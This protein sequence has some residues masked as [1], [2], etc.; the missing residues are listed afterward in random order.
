M[1]AKNKEKKLEYFFESNWFVPVY[2]V[3]LVFIAV[4]FAIPIITKFYALF[5]LSIIILIFSIMACLKFCKK[6]TQLAFFKKR[7]LKKGEKKN[8]KILGY[9]KKMLLSA[10]TD[11]EI[12][13]PENA[14]SYVYTFI[15]QVDDLKI[16]TPPLIQNPTTRL[17]SKNCSAYTDG[18]NYFIYDFEVSQDGKCCS[19]AELARDYEVDRNAKFIE[20]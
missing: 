9:K 13:M 16:E 19:L 4:F 20:K 10:M 14:D 17:K 5:I 2:S 15:V 1:K 3:V 7:M 6:D 18:K 8:A 11:I 12:P